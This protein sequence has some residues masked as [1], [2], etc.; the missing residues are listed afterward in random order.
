MYQIELCTTKLKFV[1]NLF[2]W[3]V[4]KKG[5][6]VRQLR[7]MISAIMIIALLFASMLSFIPVSKGMPRSIPQKDLHGVYTPNLD[8]LIASAIRRGLLPAEP[9]NKQVTDYLQAY[10][11]QKMIKPYEYSDPRMAERIAARESGQDIGI[12]PNIDPV[13]DDMMLVLIVEFNGTRAQDPESPFDGPL[14]NE[15]LPPGP[16][17]NTKFW[18]SDFNTGHYRTMLFD[19]TTSARSMHNYYL[20]QSY[21][22]FTVDGTVFGWVKISHTEWWYGADDPESGVD[23]LKGPVWRIVHDAIDAA[24]AQYPGIIPWA[25]FDTDHDGFVDHFA[26]VHAGEDQAAGGGAQGDDAIWSRSLSAPP[27][28]AGYDSSGKPINVSDCTIMPENGNLGVFCHEF[29]HDIGLPDTYDTIYSGESSPAFWD[30][31]ASGSWL[32]DD[33][34]LD[35]RPSHINMWGKMVLG[36][37]SPALG[38]MEHYSLSE[39]VDGEVVLMKQ[40]ETSAEG[41]KAVRIDLPQQEVYLNAPYSGNYEWWSGPGVSPADYELRRTVDLTG[42]STAQLTFSTQY[43]IETGWDFGFVQVSTDSGA[44]WTS[45]SDVEGRTTYEHDPNAITEIVDN[46]PGFTGFSDGWVHETFDLSPYAGGTIMLRFRYMTDWAVTYLG[47]FLDEITIT[48]DGA[49]IFYDGVETLVPG[50]IVSG[51]TRSTGTNIVDHYYILEWRNFVG[52]DES[53]KYAYN[54]VDY[55]AGYAERFSYNPGLLLWYRN[56]AYTDNWV[57]VHP[58]RGF[59][60]VVDSHPEPMKTPIMGYTW[61]TRVQVQD[62]TFSLQRTKSNTLTYF[63]KTKTYPSLK[64]EPMFDDSHSYYNPAKGPFFVQSSY[65]PYNIFRYPFEADAGTIVQNYGLRITVTSQDTANT[66]ANLRLLMQK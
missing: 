25:D 28:I 40:V 65:Y 5:E 14:H 29:A 8:L 16:L 32:G 33:K 23:N 2:I 17:D 46:L 60:L 36:W 15:I 56:F 7:S 39:L 48:A 11:A 57:G 47:W 10:F 45:L 3:Y 27:Y 52:F 43:E 31:M 66:W 9:T 51:W 59:L 22:V 64:G 4:K 62:A 26:V 44:T 49:T 37:V 35:T 42:K 34:T 13:G 20:E 30:L 18:I 41:I 55:A 24:N 63:G 53:L 50:W 1:H 61:R 12:D 38:N 58:G 21:G 54:F 19:A 6:G